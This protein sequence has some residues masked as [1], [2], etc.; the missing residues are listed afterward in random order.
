MTLIRRPSSVSDDRSRETSLETAG[1]G[2]ARG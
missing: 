1:A 2:S